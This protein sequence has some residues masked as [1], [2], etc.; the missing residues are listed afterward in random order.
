SIGVAIANAIL[1][2][3]FAEKARRT[4]MDSLAAAREGGQGRLRPILMTSIAMIAGML[5]MA[6]ALE[7]GGEQ[8]SP[9]GRA[10]IGGLVCA[11]FA[12]LLV[13]PAVFAVAPRFRGIRSVSVYP[14]DSE[15][16]HYAGVPEPAAV[17]PPE[18]A[19]SP[20]AAAVHP[21]AR[22]LDGVVDGTR[23]TTN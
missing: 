14:F 17:P 22:V 10:V 5:P 8:T 7:E 4:G 6:L 16:S 13:L 9:L 3:T 15:S 20:E 12:T 2:V 23:G 1:L 21:V 11:T 19:E 18:A